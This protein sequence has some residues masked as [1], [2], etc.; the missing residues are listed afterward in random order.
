MNMIAAALL[1]QMLFQL[2]DSRK[3]L[4]GLVAVEFNQQN[5]AGIAVQKLAQ[6]GSFGIDP[7]AVEHVSVDNLNR[8]RLV[9]QNC[10]SR[11]Q[12]IEQLF[13]VNDYQGPV[14]GQFDQA[15]LC[16]RGDSQCAF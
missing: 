3:Q 1:A 7:G 13:E 9:F 12:G 16:F 11:A 14:P 6:P 15:Q 10:R 4:A 5:G 8:R 2:Q